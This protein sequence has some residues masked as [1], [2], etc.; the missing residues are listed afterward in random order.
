LKKQ[1]EME[2]LTVEKTVLKYF[3]K[4]DCYNSSCTHQKSAH[5]NNKDVARAN[6][7]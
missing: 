1:F 2:L 6:V 3:K 4:Y 7:R 5:V